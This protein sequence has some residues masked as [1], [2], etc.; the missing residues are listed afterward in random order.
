MYFGKMK[1]ATIS[2]VYL[3]LWKIGSIP[4]T[5]TDIMLF[6][7]LKFL[8]SLSLTGNSIPSK[9]SNAD[10]G[11]YDRTL[12]GSPVGFKSRQNNIYPHFSY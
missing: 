12:L 7:T 5:L 4:K 2:L 11:E 8:I 10:Y 1:S 3:P 9:L 6:N